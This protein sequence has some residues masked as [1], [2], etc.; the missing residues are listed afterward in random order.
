MNMY[1]SSL[2]TAPIKKSPNH[3]SQTVG[4]QSKSSQQS[5]A[6]A[7]ITYKH[8]NK[9]RVSP[10]FHSNIICDPPENETTNP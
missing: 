4:R 5:Y 6:R 10:T 7:V 8:S 3:K 1:A 2:L 9:T